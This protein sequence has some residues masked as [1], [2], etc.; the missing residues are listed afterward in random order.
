MRGCLLPAAVPLL[1]R[2]FLSSIVQTVREREARAVTS[3]TNPFVY[4]L[5]ESSLAYVMQRRGNAMRPDEFVDTDV[6]VRRDSLFVLYAVS[7]HQHLYSYLPRTMLH[8]ARIVGKHVP[9]I[10]PPL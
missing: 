8:V 4:P 1:L 7:N 5:S 3:G 9:D 6:P 2:R 10:Y